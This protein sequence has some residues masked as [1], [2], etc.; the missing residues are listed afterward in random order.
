MGMAA[1]T[2]PHLKPHITH[3]VLYPKLAGFSLLI[4]TPVFAFLWCSQPA[5]YFFARL[6]SMVMEL[7]PPVV[8]VVELPPAMMMTMTR[9]LSQGYCYCS[10][11]SASGTPNFQFH[12]HRY[13]NPTLDT[14]SRLIIIFHRVESYVIP[15]TVCIIRELFRNVYL[16]GCKVGVRYETPVPFRRLPHL[17]C[18]AWLLAPRSTPVSLTLIGWKFSVVIASVY[19]DPYW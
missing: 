18:R 12:T 2:I 4:L 1:E 5:W 7:I 11:G 3:R 19:L 10:G 13:P 6:Q 9:V 16:A 15:L 8:D 14:T 17:P